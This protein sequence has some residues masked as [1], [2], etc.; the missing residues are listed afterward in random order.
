MYAVIFKADI[1]QFDQE[2]DDML[3]EMRELAVSQY[4]CINIQ[5][6]TE[7]EN[8]ITISYWNSLEDIK[9]W[10]QDERH[11]MAQKLG[12]VKWYKSYQ[13]QVV[14]VIKDYSSRVQ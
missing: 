3:V 14:E 6:V 9:A 13:V 1:N 12:K 7:G 10:K 5:S 4:G 11:Q 2:Y 8:E